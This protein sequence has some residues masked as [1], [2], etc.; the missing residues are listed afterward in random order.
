MSEKIKL[1]TGLKLKIQKIGLFFTILLLGLIP[2]YVECQT[3]ISGIVNSYTSVISVNSSTCESSINVVDASLFAPGEKALI[4]QMKGADVDLTNTAAF[5]SITNYNSAGLYEFFT[6]IDVNTATN[7]IVTGSFNNTYDP[8]GVLQL[9]RVPSYDDVTVNGTLTGQAWNGAT[10]GVIAVYATNT[11]NLGADIDATQLGFR[12]VTTPSS[13]SACTATNYSFNS[14]SPD[15]ADKGEGIAI[16]N[17][18]F[19]RGRGAWANAGGGANIHNAGGGGGGNGGGGGRGGEQWQGCGNTL[20]GANQFAT[21]G[22]GGY[23]MPI[24]PTFNRLFLG[25]TGGSGDSNNGFASNNTEG[26]GIVIIRA[27]H[28]NGNGFAIRSIGGTVPVSVGGAID[29]GSGGGAGGSVCLDLETIG[30]SAL[31][32]DVHGGDG[33]DI[34]YR[35]NDAHGPGGGGGGGILW[36]N[37]L[38]LPANIT[39]TNNGGREGR[40]LQAP[41]AGTP[42]GGLAGLPGRII[43]SLILQEIDDRDNDGL[44]ANCDIDDDNDGIPD[45]IELCGLGAT[46]FTCLGGTD[47]GLDDDGDGII[48]YRDPDYCTLNA[49][50]VCASMDADGDGV[51]NHLDLDADNDGIADIVEAGGTD[52]NGDGII[53]NIIDERIPEGYSE[54]SCGATSLVI[55]SPTTIPG[56]DDGIT[57]V[58]LPFS[59]EYFGTAFAG[60]LQISMNA[61]VSFDGIAPG[62]NWVNVTF[63]NATYTNTIALNWTDIAPHNGGTVRYG[64]NGVAPNRIFIVEYN[65]TPFVGNTGTATMQLQLYETTNEIRMVTTNFNPSGGT[66]TMGLNQNGT[67]AYTVTGRNN[68]GYNITTPEC[69]GLTYSLG[70]IPNGL[71]DIYDTNPLPTADT[72][73]DGIPDFLDLDADN[74]GI[75][76]VVEAGGTDANGDGRADNYV[77]TDRD[78]F[79]DIVD[80]DIGNDGT[81]ENS[82]NALLLT[83]ADGNN[84]GIPDNYPS[85]DRDGDGVL[86]HLDLDADNDGIADVVEAGGTDRNGDGRADNYVDADGDGFN[87]VVDGDPTNTLATG[88]DTNGANTDNATV[89]TGADVNNDGAPDTYPTDDNDQ[90]GILDH[91]DLDADNDGIADVVEAGGTDANGDGRAD[92]YVD[93]DG[94]GFNDVVDGDPTNALTTGTDTNGG[95]TANATV[96]TGADGNNDGVPDSYP[97]DD[98]DGDGILDHLDLDADNDGIADVVEAGGTDAN[99][100]GR[101]DNYVD[102]DGDG[103]N[104]AVDGDPTNALAL[105]TDTNGANT[106][107]AL[108]LTGADTNGDGVPNSYIAGDTDGD[109]ILDHLDLD[110]DNDGIADVVEAGGTDANGDGR[111]DNYVDA[112]GDGFNDAVDGDPT[113]ALVLGTDTNGANTNDALQLTGADTNGDGIPN[114][115]IA[116]D[117]DGD[118]ILDHL[119]LDADNDGIPDVVEAGGTDVNGDGRAD[120]YVD[121]DGDGFNDVVDGDPTNALTAGTDTNGSNTANVTTLTGA[122]TNGD[123][124]PDSYPNDDLD[125]DGILNAL[126]L[127]ADN[128]GI[129]DIVEAGGIDANRDGIADN[130]VDAD[131]DGFNDVVD[132]DPTN[133][134]ALGTDTNGTNTANATTLT[135]ADTNG[136]GVP[137]SYPNDNQDGDNNYNFLDIDA[138]N[139]GIV[140][141]TE[142]QST[143][144]YIAPT[145]LDADGDGI[146]DA[147]DNDDVNFGGA[148]SGIVPNNQDGTDNPDYLDLDTDN[149]GIA[150]V[151]EGHDTNGDGVVDGSDGPNSNTGLPGGIADVDGDGLL[152]GYDNNTASTDATNTTLN[153]DSYPDVTNTITVERDWREGNTTY[154]TNDINTTP[155]NVMTSGNVV[156]NDDDQEGNAQVLTSI[157]ID[158]DGNGIPETTAGLGVGITVGGV[159]EDGTSNLN[160]GTLTQNSDGTYTFVPTTGFIGEVTYTYDVCDNGQPQACATAIVTIDVEP[161]PTTDNGELAPAPDV[162]TTYNDL[163]VSGQVLSNDNDPDGDNILVTGTIQI[164]TDGDGMVDAT[165]NL[166]ILT[167]IAGVDVAG[168]PVANVGTLIQNANGTYTFDPVPGFIGVVEYVYTACDDGIPITCE[169]TTVTINVLPSVYNS[170]NAIDDEE[171]MDKGTTLTDNVL[172]NDTDVEGDNQVGGVTL[173][174]GTTNGVVTLNPNGTYSYTPTDPNFSGND[175]FVYSVCDNGTPQVCDTATVYITILDVNRDYGDGPAVYGEAYHRAIRDVNS[176][177][178]LDGSTD[179]WFGANTDFENTNLSVGTDNFDD[180]IALGTSTSGSFP[181]TVAPSTLYNVDLNLNSVGADN[182][183]YGMWIDWNADGI[184][185]DFYSG[186]VAVPGGPFVTNVA[187]TSPGALAT[188]LVNIRIRLDDS[189]LGIGDFQGARTNGE[190]EDYQFL[191]NDPLP[192]ELLYFTARLEGNNTG[193]LNWATSSELNNAGYEVEQALPSTGGL[194][195]FNQIGYVTGK[196]TTTTEQNYAYDVLNL[197]PGVHYFRLK[198][199][200]FDGTYTY[201]NIRSLTVKAPLVQGLYPTVLHKGSNVVYLQMAKDGNYKI[202]IITA[203][204]Q[205]VESY[206]ADMQSNAYHEINFDMNRYVSGIYFIRVRNDEESFTRKIRVE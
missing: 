165:A 139:D 156:T 122:D 147:Y 192:V 88:T 99:G 144:A 184:Y 182:L 190:V 51:P 198:Q 201:T 73:G 200:D 72:D 102:A 126:D 87:D 116:G 104:D 180:G 55:A 195:E 164:D 69:R 146:D 62:S 91:L 113:N 96:L 159:N 202:E 123:G 32:V 176:D 77:D 61:W 197:V 105:G 63:P 37:L 97:T 15:G 132:G 115:Y 58:P 100:D 18:N 128:D 89:L 60:N 155:T 14:T 191:M 204:G 157:V 135:G 80:G 160:A 141:N 42:N 83:G 107:D 78:G 20:T 133:A 174:T 177:N 75:P 52:T 175:E 54:N 110:A 82:S 134:L 74:D 93:A 41:N 10:G 66:N 3:P 38:T 22:V 6:I 9:V 29:G 194:L 189:P 136:D 206:D 28:L 67:T 68:T 43:T 187:V 196:G 7:T 25:G 179:V 23:A 81:A 79:N 178:V 4:I 47:P 166:G 108:Q 186:T 57:G 183:S 193:K 125:G 35:G 117:T 153:P 24:G 168:N 138:D 8:S 53:D 118:G 203:L 17:A 103:F 149:D 162:N 85:N 181:R 109:G 13:A 16:T 172:T 163:A 171:F 65:N 148:G 170:T 33:Q 84:D 145:G 151:I 142:G 154:G 119:D 48:N 44:S 152:D 137:N 64:T 94:D 56:T 140:D 205:L 150:D 101:A 40:M 49:N 121:V 92:N 31:T 98:T 112:D 2:F 71:A 86:D 161:E 114:S 50:G 45:V 26:G 90:D 199:V 131:G 129:L 19:A 143:S 59:F 130:Y 173:V 5:G 124:V 12:G 21:G 95:N 27:R 34:D 158:T 106:N 1:Q 76:D 169:Q 36:H 39:V 167:N 70:V 127:D 111:A 188:N 120:D 30:A 185:D 46:D 11:V